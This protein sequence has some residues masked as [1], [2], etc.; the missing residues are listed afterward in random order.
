MGFYDDMTPN[1]RRRIWFERGM[2]SAE[3][4]WRGMTNEERDQSVMEDLAE[5]RLSIDDPLYADYYERRMAGRSVRGSHSPEALERF[6]WLE[7]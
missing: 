7:D 3:E 2:L 1:E 6:P 4:Y 5:G